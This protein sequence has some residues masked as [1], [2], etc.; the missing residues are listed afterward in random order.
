MLQDVRG[1]LGMLSAIEEG[2]SQWAGE[3]EVL[4]DACRQLV[5][6]YGTE[7]EAASLQKGAE[8]PLWLISA[9]KLLGSG[10]EVDTT[11]GPPSS[12]FVCSE[13]LAAMLSPLLRIVVEWQPDFV[14][15]VRETLDEEGWKRI[16]VPY[17][18]FIGIVGTHLCDP[19]WM[20]YPRL[21]PPGW[22]T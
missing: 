11:A 22:P 8:R 19:M 15:D 1:Q 10:K 16:T 7:A 18:Q 9:L 12:K 17:G 14:A 4:L 5:E 13:A 20:K 6:Y 3:V 21:A 2:I